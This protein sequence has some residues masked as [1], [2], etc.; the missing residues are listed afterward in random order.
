MACA[1]ILL[2]RRTKS[3]G[4]SPRRGF[5]SLPGLIALLGLVDDIDPALAPH[6]AVVAMA[7][8]Q[9]FQRIT[10]FHG[11]TRGSSRVGMAPSAD[12]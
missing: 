3:K 8:A 2:R 5:L 6:E 7:I 4:R 12:K 10:D 11:I 1:R 9:R